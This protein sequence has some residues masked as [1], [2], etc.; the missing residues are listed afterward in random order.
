MCATAMML[1]F[2]PGQCTSVCERSRLGGVEQGKS[3]QGGL[4]GGLLSALMCLTAAF[5]TN[6]SVLLGHV[7]LKVMQEVLEE[8]SWFPQQ[9]PDQQL[10]ND[11]SEAHFT[12]LNVRVVMFE[13][14]QLFTAGPE[15]LLQL[16]GVSTC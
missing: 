13:I 10:M 7:T 5:A 12:A 1:Q 8:Q 11:A 2:S 3:G 4:T 9:Q 6:R 15:P 16:W 14:K